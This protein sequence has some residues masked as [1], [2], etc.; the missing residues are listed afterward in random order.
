MWNAAWKG[1]IGHRLRFA[2]TALSIALGVGLVAASY[3]FTDS[4]D[5]AFDDL[6]SATLSGFDLQVRPEVDEDLAFTQGAPLPMAL[7]DEIAALPGIDAARGSIF[8]FAQVSARGQSLT[9]GT[10]PTFVV[11]WPELVDAFM[12]RSGERPEAEEGAL[13]PSTAA[14]AG[15]SLGDEIVV[16]GVGAPQ[17]LQLSGT[18]A[19]EGFESFGGAV[20]VYVTLETAQELLDLDGQVLTVEIETDQPLEEMIERIETILPE[21]IEAVSAQSAAEEQLQT[22]KEAL[23]FLNTFLLVFAGV[24][25]FVAAFLIQNTFRI[26]VAQR[27]H[28]LATLRLVGASRRQVLSLVLVEAGIVGLVASGLGLALG[29]VLARAIRSLLAFGGTLPAARFELAPRT[30]GVAVATG[31]VI[32]IG[33]ALLPARGASRINPIAALRRVQAPESPA[34]NRRRGIV[35]LLITVAGVGLL[36]VGLLGFDLPVSNL[37]LV[38]FGAGLIFIGV[39][40]L[41]AV[42]ARPVTAAVGAPLAQLGVPGRLAVDN[43]GR[44]PRRTAATAS[45]LMVG[46]ALVG[47]TLVL[48]DSLKTTADRLIGDRFE[49]DLVVAPTG[50]GA[51]RLSPQLA[52]DLAELGEVAYLAAVRDGQVLYRDET[53]T[54]LGG[55]TAL[56]PELINFTLVEGDIADISGNRIGMRSSLA[57]GLSIG[58]QVT[59]EFART[60][61]QTL[62]LAAIFDARGIGAGLLVDSPTFAANFTEQFDSQI[63]VDLA[64]GVSHEEGRAQVESVTAGYVGSQVLDQNELASEAER[65]IDELVRLVFGLLGVAV[66]IALI[67]ITNTLT[68]SVLERRREIGLLRAVGLSRRQLRAAINWEAIVI[69]LLGA[70]LGMGLGLV[71]AWAVIGALDDE[72]LRMSIPWGR[73]GL[74]LLGAGLAGLVAAAVPAWRASRRNILEAISYE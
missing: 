19:I 51:S 58:D 68:L 63:F 12:V 23:G 3:M 7:V 22:F 32:T 52:A 27:T 36:V 17:S 47:L 39:A 69:A 37:V 20:S 31:L 65:R 74:S 73:V 53:R 30:I 35:G 43:A 71:F 1:L 5:Q 48:A 38:G 11:S 4:L 41:A 45:A 60:G 34:T 16:T 46:L 25:V 15:L 6:F 55:P 2:L 54:L 14:R 8:G 21:G 49:A 62:E 29:V 24:T 57:E 18:A 70:L 56:L 64:G 66:V 28:E 10:S 33:S 44:S 42:F 26:I 50:F 61:P 9:N 40:V 13:D 67:G 72:V 59:I